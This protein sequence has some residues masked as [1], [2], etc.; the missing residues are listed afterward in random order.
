MIPKQILDSRRCKVETSQSLVEKLSSEEVE[1]KGAIEAVDDMISVLKTFG[2][3]IPFTLGCNAG[4]SRKPRV[5]I[6]SC[7]MKESKLSDGLLEL[8]KLLEKDLEIFYNRVVGERGS[9]VR[10]VLDWVDFSVPKKEK[11]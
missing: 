2:G 9:T 11:K 4:G 5:T 8:K 10:Q 3:G 1:R 6:S 7:D